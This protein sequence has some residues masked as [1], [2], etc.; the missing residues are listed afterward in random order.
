MK[1]HSLSLA[2]CALIFA[3][4]VASAAPKSQIKE[5]G[6]IHLTA[7]LQPAADAPA[8]VTAT[9]D[10]V[11][12]KTKF[13]QAGT[14]SLTLTTSGFL[15]GDYSIDGLLDPAAPPVHLGDFSVGAID[16][17]NPVPDEP[18]T[19]AISSTIDATLLTSISISDSTPKVILEGEVTATAVNWMY[20]ANV[21]VTGPA[22]VG[23]S[24]NGKAHGPK[25]KAARGHVI[26]QSTVKNGVETKRHFL[27]VAFGAP[28]NT[29][30]TINVDGVEVGTVTSTK[31]GK[32]MFHE[33]PADVVLRDVK[34]ITLTDGDV[35]LV[36]QAQF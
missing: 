5:R 9:A 16:P 10:I 15:V 24:S 22:P 13:N 36:M 28:A 20:L 19:L 35:A 34:L 14:A 2:A 6:E 29:E 12:K 3:T 26:S 8:G 32:V 1:L 30:L 31:N 23:T 25:P 18:I 7:T 17:V 11:I 33:M 21:Q 27:W 4:A